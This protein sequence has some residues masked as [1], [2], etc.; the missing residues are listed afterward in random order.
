[1]ITELSTEQTSLIVENCFWHIAFAEMFIVCE[2]PIKFS[3]N[4]E[5]FWQKSEDPALNI[6]FADGFY[7]S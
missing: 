2:R 7:L 4:F 6:H 3:V 5:S 1:M